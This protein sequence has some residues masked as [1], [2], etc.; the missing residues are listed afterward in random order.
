M[1][2]ARGW[3]P[4]PHRFGGRSNRPYRRRRSCRSRGETSRRRGCRPAPR[5]ATSRR[6]SASR[7]SATGRTLAGDARPRRAARPL[8][9]ARRRRDAAGVRRSATT[10]AS[11]E[12]LR[13]GRK[14][15]S[16]AETGIP[17]D[18]DAD[19]GDAH[20]LGDAARSANAL[21]A[22]RTTDAGRCYQPFLARRIADGVRRAVEQPA[23]GADRLGRG[24]AS[25]RR[26]STAA[27]T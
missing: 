3:D 7:S 8:P 12:R 11:R 9:G 2:G 14:L 16:R 24:R 26:S 6:R 25:R 17:G 21:V 18:H 13:R 20:A 27:G 19:V 15:A 23:A 1:V 10:S 22:G 5:R 4:P